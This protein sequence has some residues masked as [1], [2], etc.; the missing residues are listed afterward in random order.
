MEG[1]Y[2]R[3][4]GAGSGYC[5][6]LLVVWAG[7]LTAY[8]RRI[9]IRRRYCCWRCAARLF[10]SV[11]AQNSVGNEG[12][13]HPTGVGLA[14][15]LFGPGGWRFSSGCAVISGAIAGAR[16]PDD[17]AWRKWNVDGGDWP[18]VGYLV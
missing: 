1:F 10:L 11:R 8:C 6:A 18:V 13:S 17:D 7:A 3:Q 4:C 5:F 14:V 9:I 2:R 12:C 16:R 15:I